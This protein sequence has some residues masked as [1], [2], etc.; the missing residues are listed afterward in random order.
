[1]KHPLHKR[2]EPSL[3][4]IV[5]ITPWL[6]NFTTQFLVLA[7]HRQYSGDSP[8]ATPTR[9]QPPSEPCSSA[10]AAGAK[11]TRAPATPPHSQNRTGALPQGLGLGLGLGPG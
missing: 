10:N 6:W 5:Y 9:T 11:R 2:V 8:G 4:I 3:Y 1:M 7:C